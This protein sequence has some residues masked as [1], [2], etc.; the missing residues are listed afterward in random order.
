[1]DL[2]DFSKL[3]YSALSNIVG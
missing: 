3:R 1:V 2:F